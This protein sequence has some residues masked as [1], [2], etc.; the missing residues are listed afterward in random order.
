MHRRDDDH[1]EGERLAGLSPFVAGPPSGQSVIPFR[2]ANPPR[3]AAG[4]DPSS[5]PAP[6][7]SLGSVTQ[8][9][10]LRLA[11]DAVRLKVL[12]AGPREEEETDRQP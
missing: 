4:G 1:D 11:N 3:P 9:V 10:V 12:A 7:E 5:P 8:A 2:R 6:F